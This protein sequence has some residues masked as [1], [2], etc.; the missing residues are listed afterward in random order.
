M[1]DCIFCKIINGE[2]ESVKIWENDNFIAI[3][4][5]MPNTAGMALVL[6]KKHHDSYVFNMPNNVYQEFMLASKEVAKILE[7]GLSL[8][9]VAMVM[10]GMGVNHAHIKLYPLHGIKEEFKEMWAKKEI[11]FDNYEGYISTQL[12]PRKSIGELQ[13]IADKIKNNLS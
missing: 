4:D 9:R 5:L 3:L 6:P 13:K 2:F 8:K 1:S 7:K 10:E 11:Y 12:G